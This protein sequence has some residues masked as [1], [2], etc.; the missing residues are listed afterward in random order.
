MN[1]LPAQ[2]NQ[3]LMDGIAVLQSLSVRAGP[4]T[5]TKL[6]REL[7]LELTRTN[8]LLKTLHHLGL[9]HRTQNRKYEIGPGIHVLAAQCLHS[10]GLLQKALPFL[11]ALKKWKLAAALGVLWHN[12][13]SYLYHWRPGLTTEEAIARIALYPAT[14]SSIGLTLL[15]CQAEDDIKK[16]FLNKNIAGFHSCARLL[17]AL[18][19][20]RKNGYGMVKSGAE[21]SI[22]V[23]VGEPPFAGLAV[24]GKIPVSSIHSVISKLHDIADA[25]G[26]HQ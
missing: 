23:P 7:G 8:R 9:T 15:S 21:T 12:H 19:R 26:R 11:V 5:C 18:K 2:P 4:V 24:S 16:M 1:N 13:V 3:S 22:A 14:I 17:Q 10:S 20:T 6:S 25:V